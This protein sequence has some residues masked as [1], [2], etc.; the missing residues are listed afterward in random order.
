MINSLRSLPC[1]WMP[2]LFAASALL[3]GGGGRANAQPKND[4]SE[5]LQ[6][7]IKQALEELKK[8][9]PKEQV[10]ELQRR[11]EKVQGDLRGFAP[12][13]PQGGR[14]FGVS[15]IGS[16]FG[17]VVQVPQPVVI[18]QLDLP[19]NKGLVVL[20]VQPNS[21][22][23]KAGIRKN[24]ILLEFAGKAVPSDL[25][26]FTKDVRDHKLGEEVDAVVLRRGKRETI[27]G[28]KLAE[29]Q[30]ALDERF[31]RGLP[32]IFPAQRIPD[33]AN[34]PGA[35]G[36]MMRVRVDNDGFL[37]ELTNGALKATLKGTREN[38]KMTPQEIRIQ[39]GDTVVET[40]DM[41]QVPERYRPLLARMLGSVGA[42]P[43][44]PGGGGARR[45]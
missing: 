39:D 23:E 30:A 21:P 25:I 19:A 17:A 32:A 7:Q 15:T 8:I 4:D 28:I 40:R 11:L 33:V 12:R 16:R 41:T 3:L 10:D 42:A 43:A 31:G 27:K 13:N 18:D 20:D 45:E 29:F 36:D 24:D 37:V 14:R 38:N 26:D 2:A 5:E 35:N 22:A 44:G 9:D 1:R 34:L 6:R